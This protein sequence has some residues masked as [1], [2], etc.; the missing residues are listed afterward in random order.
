MNLVIVLMTADLLL[1]ENNNMH[2]ENHFRTEYHIIDKG[3][4]YATGALF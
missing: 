4:I 3:M 1:R 2:K